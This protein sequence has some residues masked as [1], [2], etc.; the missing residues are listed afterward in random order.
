MTQPPRRPLDHPRSQLVHQALLDPAKFRDPA[1][2]AGG[3]PRAALALA[4]LETLWLNTGT[5]CNIECRRCYIESSPRNDRLA[6]L[7]LADAL[8]FLDEIREA[9]WPTRAIGLTGGE[10]FMNPDVLALLDACLARGFRVLVLT[11]A[12]RPM[13]RHARALLA[14]R[15]RYERDLTL[16]VSLDHYTAELHEAER[17]PRSFEPTLAGLRWLLDGGF[18]ACV[19]GRTFSGEDEARLRKEYARLFAERGLAI[20]AG[21][22]AALVLFPEMDERADVPEITT[23]CFD[24]LGVDPGSLMCA[25]SRMVVKRRG[26]E[27][28]VV[29][30]CTLLPYDP[31]FELGR[32][33]A[34]SAG[35]VALNQPHCA[36]F[37]VLGGGSCQRGT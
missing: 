36:R 16:R 14:L 21:D 33:L 26:D 6:Y 25:T 7:R 32:T 34:D 3:E 29:L 35:P 20:D 24:K 19:A 1:R 10:P 2:T 17:G 31:R 30:P 9:G 8:P 28:P 18:A 15:A 27:R 4:A 37:C 5:R 13:M 11:N 23:S 22:P 12:M